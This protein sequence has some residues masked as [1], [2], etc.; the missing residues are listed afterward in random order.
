MLVVADIRLPDDCRAALNTEGF[1][2]IL[3]PPFPALAEPV[4]SHPD[5]L[6]FICGNMLL[7][8][9]SYYNI[10]EKEI[11]RIL[12]AGGLTLTLSD[13]SVGCKYPDDVRFNAACIG[14]FIFGKAS[15]VSHHITDICRSGTYKFIDIKQG[16]SKCST[17][18]V[19]DSALITADRSI[20]RNAAA[21]GLDVLLVSPE[22]IQLEGYDRGFIGGASGCCGNNV[23]FCGSLALHPDGKMIQAFCASHGKRAV[24]LGSGHL[25]DAGTLF[26][27]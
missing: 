25:F 18:I 23:Y 13:E 7:T 15:A 1:E 5:M 26:F 19:C 12:E 16:Y 9:R 22:G 2:E 6:I 3:L 8:H 4:A 14:S 21:H 17:C 20:A 10:A 27:I 11:N 24:S